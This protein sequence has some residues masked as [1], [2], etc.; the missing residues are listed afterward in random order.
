M[1]V[2]ISSTVVWKRTQSLLPTNILQPMSLLR[3]ASLEAGALF[4]L[5]EAILSVSSTCLFRLPHVSANQFCTA[6]LG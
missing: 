3:K 2:W 6:E 1:K 5:R 4:F